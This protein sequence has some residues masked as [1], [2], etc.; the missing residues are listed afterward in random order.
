MLSLGV[1][2]AGATGGYLAGRLAA[3]GMDVT[4]LTRPESAEVLREDGL[5]LCEPNGEERHVRT[6]R[7]LTDDEHID[8]VDIT[9]FCVKSYQTKEALDAAR[10]LTGAGGVVL[11]LQ[12]GVE[13]EQLLATEFGPDRVLAGVLYIGAERVAPNV[14]K[15]SAPPRLRYG[16]F[17]PANPPQRSLE[18]QDVFAGLGIDCALDPDIVGTKWQKWIFNCGLNPLTALTG[19]TLGR[20][21]ADTAGARLFDSLVDEAIDVASAAEGHLTSSNPKEDVK[22]VADRMD[23]S[24]SMA[25]DLAA[26]RPLEIQAFGGYVHR[27]GERQ[28]RSTP[29]TDVVTDL[30]H[31]VSS[32]NDRS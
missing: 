3:G 15:C 4:V 20:I 13:N 14:I 5:L 31:I 9:L 24:S 11:C 8:P 17:V 29:V 12:N 28:G 25:E 21:R 23:I 18:I 2:G 7:V 16:P 32:R 22:V 26:G 6:M 27:L 1:V 10:A 30:L 19:M